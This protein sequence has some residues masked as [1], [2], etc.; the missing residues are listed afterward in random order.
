MF[1][2]LDEGTG[3]YELAT[4]V[5]EAVGAATV[6]SGSMIPSAFGACPPDLADD[7]QATTAESSSFWLLHIGPVLLQDK[8]RA[9]SVYHHHFCRL[10]SITDIC[11]QFE[12]AKEEIEQLRQDCI[13]W[14]EDYEKYV[15]NDYS[16]FSTL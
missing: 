5:W 12:H 8:F 14:V 13:W 3:S 11:L 15:S 6:A 9:S 10:S 4:G 16:I 2:G 1:K 7:K